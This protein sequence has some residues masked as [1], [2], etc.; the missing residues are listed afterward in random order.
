M[1]ALYIYY[2]RD[3]SGMSERGQRSTRYME[4]VNLSEKTLR[5]PR[6]FFRESPIVL[7]KSRKKV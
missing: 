5:R 2:A 1:R 4:K 6:Y 7:G 3:M